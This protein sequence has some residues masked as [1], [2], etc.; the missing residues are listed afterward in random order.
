MRHQ[1]AFLITCIITSSPS[2]PALPSPVPH[3]LVPSNLL[4]V[5]GSLLDDPL[6]S[7][8]EFVLPTLSAKKRPHRRIFATRTILKRVDYFNTSLSLEAFP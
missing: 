4:D 8:V 6:Y 1:D 2:P 7:D 5:V 3:R